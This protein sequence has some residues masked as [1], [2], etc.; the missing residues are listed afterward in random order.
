MENI[1]IPSLL[2]TDF[3][4]YVRKEFLS[5]L[6]LLTYY[7]KKREEIFLLNKNKIWEFQNIH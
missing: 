1:N 4:I 7:D 2:G 3:Y 5:L 6:G